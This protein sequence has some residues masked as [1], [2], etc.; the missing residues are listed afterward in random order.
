MKT[1]IGALFEDEGLVTISSLVEIMPELV[2][3]GAEVF[4]I[5]P[6]THLETEIFLVVDVPCARVANHITVGWLT[7]QR[8]LPECLW[9]GLGYKR[10]GES[11]D[12]A[13]D[14]QYLG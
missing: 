2:M 4:V 6:N 3:S 10:G 9:Q 11:H 14:R 8:P 13:D 7:E 1:V 12:I 5:N